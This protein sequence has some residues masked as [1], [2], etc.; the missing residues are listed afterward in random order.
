MD[1][2]DVDIGK[3]RTLLS[4]DGVDVSNYSDD[5]LGVL[6]DSKIVELEGLIGADIN[7]RERS[8][9]LGDYCGD[10]IELNF[11]PVVDIVSVFVDDEC[12]PSRE[13]NV[14]RDLGIIYFDSVKCGSVRI[15]YLSGVSDRDMSHLILP[16]LKDM[17]GDTV[18]Y[19]NIND[20]IGGYGGVASSMHEGDVSI[21]LGNWGVDGSKGGF[22]YSGSVNSR[23]GDLVEKYSARKTRV[24]WL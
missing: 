8:K 22:G 18:K 7:P 13:Y 12:V 6:I 4:F 23:I 24:R 10:I 21:S 14:N 5:D 20:M 16:L 19:K 1:S 2:R 3:L 9:V 17:I 11:Y 15:L